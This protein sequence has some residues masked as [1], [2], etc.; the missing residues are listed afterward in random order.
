MSS[1]LLHVIFLHASHILPSKFVYTSLFEPLFWS[2]HDTS[3]LIA[4]ARSECSY[5]S[6]QTQQSIRCSLTQSRDVDEGSDLNLNVWPLW[7]RQHA[8]IDLEGSDRGPGPPT[9][10]KLKAIA[11]LSNTGPDPLK[12]KKLPSQY[13]MMGYYWPASETTYSLTRF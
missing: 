7:I 3:V 5:E 8:C 9:L 13:S 12:N 4:S 10:K 1:L 2:V 6:T 11:F